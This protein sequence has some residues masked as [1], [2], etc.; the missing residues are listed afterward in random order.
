M[1]RNR[2]AA[3]SAT[4]IP[5]KIAP[6]GGAVQ[7]TDGDRRTA[8]SDSEA[9]VR[10]SYSDVASSRPLTPLIKGAV[11]ASPTPVEDS[12]VGVSLA[13]VVDSVVGVPGPEG[14]P[15]LTSTLQS[16][17]DNA[18]MT[19]DTEN[20]RKEATKS[21]DEWI[22]IIRRRAFPPRGKPTHGLGRYEFPKEIRDPA[23]EK[24]TR[25][26]NKEQLE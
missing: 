18:R 1:L 9:D 25:N 8:Y 7:T 26:L 19:S 21:N 2:K 5:I 22:K 15:Q 17:V 6:I 10:R 16:N 23:I 24:A 12:A 4:A 3:G 11:G 20:I 13:P 14:R